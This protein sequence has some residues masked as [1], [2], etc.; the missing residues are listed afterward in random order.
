MGHG[1]V[2]CVRANQAREGATYQNQERENGT[3]HNARGDQDNQ[4]QGATHG[5]G[6]ATRVRGGQR[7][8]YLHIARATPTPHA[9]PEIDDDGF[10]TVDYSLRRRQ[11]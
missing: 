1:E 11:Y 5:S 7:R 3:R 10:E 6:Q 8:M 9:L 4:T 2:I